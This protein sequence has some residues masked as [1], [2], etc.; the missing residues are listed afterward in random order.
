MR[1]VLNL[2]IRLIDNLLGAIVYRLGRLT[3]TQVRW[4]RFPLA[5]CF[6]ALSSNGR[7]AAF[8]AVNLRSSRSGAILNELFDNPEQLLSGA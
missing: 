8:G 1:D 4:V 7:T 6:N 2:S 5:L 3:F